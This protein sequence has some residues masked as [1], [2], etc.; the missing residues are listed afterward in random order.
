MP[1][2]L[3]FNP[4]FDPRELNSLTWIAAGLGKRFGNA[5]GADQ[6][7]LSEHIIEVILMNG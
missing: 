5:E 6:P 3:S 7:Q 4:G 1:L 2:F